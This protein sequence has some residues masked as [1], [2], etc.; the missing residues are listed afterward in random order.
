MKAHVA[1]RSQLLYPTEAGRAKITIN[2]TCEAIGEK[3]LKSERMSSVSMFI[4]KEH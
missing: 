3:E 4:I 1:S 2:V